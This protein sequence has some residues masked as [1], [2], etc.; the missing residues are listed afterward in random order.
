MFD[1]NF[2]FADDLAAD[3]GASVVSIWLTHQGG[4]RNLAV[5][6]SSGV[7]LPDGWLPLG[8]RGD[9]WRHDDPATKYRAFSAVEVCC[10][11]RAD[12]R[13]KSHGQHAT[14]PKRQRRPE[15]LVL[16]ERINNGTKFQRS[17]EVRQRE[18]Q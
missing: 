13:S 15:I 2:D 11:R 14:L 9:R 4:N 6:L 16:T 12:A 10:I 8:V 3:C 7:A 17:N 5:L 18:A 1:H